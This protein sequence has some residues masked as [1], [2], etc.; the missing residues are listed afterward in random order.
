MAQQ[1][2]PNKVISLV[3]FVG[4]ALL[5][6]YIFRTHGLSEGMTFPEVWAGLAIGPRGVAVAAFIASAYGLGALISNLTRQR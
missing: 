6:Y 3:F 4:G 2:G 5:A 1:R